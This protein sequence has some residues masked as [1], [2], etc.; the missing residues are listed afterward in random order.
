MLFILSKIIS[1][2]FYASVL[3]NILFLSILYCFVVDPRN[4]GL[5]SSGFKIY[6]TEIKES[7][8]YI[9][10]FLIV[11]SVLFLISVYGEFG[12]YYR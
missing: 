4:H 6:S 9:G 1:L 7:S 3:L 12:V 5:V 11:Q 2:F 10:V 8:K